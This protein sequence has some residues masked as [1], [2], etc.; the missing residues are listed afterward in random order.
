MGPEQKIHAI[1]SYH[2]NPFIGMGDE[3]D[4]ACNVESIIRELRD[5]HAGARSS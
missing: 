5:A 4:V 3:G 1:D 2:G